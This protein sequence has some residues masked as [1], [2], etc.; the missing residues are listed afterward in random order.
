M[1]IPILLANIMIL[2]DFL[3]RK[4]KQKKWIINYIMHL[5]VFWDILKRKEMMK[6]ENTETKGML[7]II[8]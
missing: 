1:I 8:E 6:L 7:C 5:A 2:Q 4:R 3:K